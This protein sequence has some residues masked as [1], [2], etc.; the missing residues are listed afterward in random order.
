MPNGQ[1]CRR[2]AALIRV[3]ILITTQVHREINLVSHVMRVPAAALSCAVRRNCGCLTPAL[4]FYE[5]SAS[6]YVM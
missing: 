2:R 6:V 5:L 4:M 1:G 3:C